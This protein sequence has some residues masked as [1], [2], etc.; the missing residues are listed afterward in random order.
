M[1]RRLIARRRYMREHRWTHEHLS[2]YLDADLAPDEAAR[3]EDHAGICPQCRRVLATL[4]RTMEGLR[5]LGTESQSEIADGVIAR[6]RQ[7]P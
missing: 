4:R 5:A 6:L 2:S 7:E 3:V 1:I